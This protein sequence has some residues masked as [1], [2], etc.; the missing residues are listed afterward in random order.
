MSKTLIGIGFD[1]EDR[2]KNKLLKIHQDDDNRPNHTF[3]FGAPGVGK[4]RLLEGMIEQ[5]IPKGDNLV[6]IDP[7]GDIGLFSKMFEVARQSGRKDEVMLLTPIYPEFSIE[8]NPLKNFHLEEEVIAH[9]MSGVPAADEFFV[10]VAYET[11]TAIVKALLMLR[12]A[13]KNE[14][15]LNFTEIASKAYYNGIVELKAELENLKNNPE[16]LGRD[17]DGGDL[18]KLLNLFNQV[19]SSPQDYF[20]KVSSTL[21]TTLT[22]MTTGNIGAIIG[23]AA[24][25]T[26]IERLEQNKGVLLYVMTGSMLTRQVSS[27]ISKVCISMIQSCVG[28][29]YASGS[30][31]ERRLNLYI[32]EM[33]S[34]VYAGIEVLYAQARAANVAITGLTQSTA[35]IIAEI[36]RDRANKLLDLT[37][38]KIIMRM[39]EIASAKVISDLGGKRRS[40]SYFLNVEGGITS[41]EVEEL[42]VEA[43][44]ITTLAKREF[45][46]FG[47]EGRFKGK[48]APVKDGSVKIIMP[49]IVKHK[50]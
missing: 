13:E 2:K 11:T 4:T 28:R 47:F 32:D 9:I 41:R 49:E 37:S 25:N 38:T 26:F 23:D 14:M 42:N 22:Q 6:I 30:K 39:N 5:D 12:R 27:I 33:A 18:E 10:N 7:K 50:G 3:I 20:S 43:D 35:D 24:E 16:K 17:Q 8:I 19:L 45:Y 40:F 1:I 31:M 46:Y 21:R 34:S 36:G 48:T 44:D 29:I 15:P